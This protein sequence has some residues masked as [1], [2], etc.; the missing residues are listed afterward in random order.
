MERI[1]ECQWIGPEQKGPLFRPTCC[2]PVVLGRA[3]CEEHLWRVYSK[4][5]AL[6]KRHKDIKRA[7]ATWDLESTINDIVQE[8]VDEGEIEVGVEELKV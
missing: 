2:Q 1:T 4:G 7:N 3:Y 6:R 8:L 5:T